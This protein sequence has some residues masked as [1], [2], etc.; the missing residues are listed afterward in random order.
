[1]SEWKVTKPVFCICT[2]GLWSS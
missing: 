1:M 2:L